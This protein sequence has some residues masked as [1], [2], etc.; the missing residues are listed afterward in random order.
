MILGKCFMCTPYITKHAAHASEKRDIGTRFP[1]FGVDKAKGRRYNLRERMLTRGYRLQ[2]ALVCYWAQQAIDQCSEIDDAALAEYVQPVQEALAAVRR[3]RRVVFIGGKGCGKTAL[4]A[5]VSGHEIMAKA[6]WEGAYVCWRYRCTDGDA[7]ASRFLPDETLEGLELVDTAPCETAG[8]AIAKLLPGADVIVAVLDGRAPQDSPVWPLL[9]ALPENAA[10]T[11]LLA[12]THTDALSADA[13][14]QLGQSIRDL[15]RDRLQAMPAACHVSPGNAAAIESFTTRVQEALNAPGGIRAALRRVQETAEN[16]IYK[17]G[18]VLK[19][20]EDVMRLDTG[21]L[22]GIEQE[23][24]NFLARQQ[25]GSNMLCDH[26]TDAVRRVRPRLLRR[27]GRTF[28]WFLSPVTLLRLEIFGAGVEKVYCS[29]VQQEVNRLQEENDRNFTL[30]CAA[31][32]KSVR[33][34]MKQTLDCEI[35]DFPEEELA[36][37][38]AQLRSRMERDLYE[39]FLQDRVRPTLS[40]VFREPM[41]WMR[42]LIIILCLL[43]A[44]AGFVGY[45]G[46]DNM[47]C[48]IIG[49]AGLLWIAG[50]I[51]HLIVAHRLKQEITNISEKLYTTM[52]GVLRPVVDRLIIS[53]VAAYRRL[54]TTPRQKV[55]DREA[56]LQPMQ[57]RHSEIH[58]M[59]RAAAPRL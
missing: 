46:Q 39:P 14:L 12:L 8:E 25:Q 13:L 20:R 22:A 36:A 53:R 32:W 35:G 37:E 34:R 16:L 57:Q 27:F 19:K 17:Q 28:G 15:C 52:H 24:E 3:D 50:S 56:N 31:H 40:A 2:E 43:L 10:G 21:F 1:A 11:L 42:A 9:A 30:S 51:G 18:S 47:A 33:P 7:T 4:L 55:S 41:G 45:L 38:L 49:A 29:M 6:P 44:T 5:A 59:I 54:Y 48:D 23:I 58:R 26:F